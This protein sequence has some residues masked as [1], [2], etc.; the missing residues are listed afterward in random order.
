MKFSDNFIKQFNKLKF[1]AEKHSPEIL[2][3]VGIV[4]FGATLYYTVRGTV[5]ASETLSYVSEELDS[6]D[7]ESASEKRSLQLSA[8]SDVV[9]AYAPAVI[10]GS[11][12]LASFLSS[13]H[14]MRN[15]ALSM[16]AAYT[17]LETGFA[18]YR[19]R[20]IEKYG[21]DTD[22]ELKYGI[23]QKKVKSAEIDPKTGKKSKKTETVDT[24]EKCGPFGVYFKREYEVAKT[25]KTI[26]NENWQP[27]VFFN[28]TFLNAQ[29]AYFNG[30][31]DRGERVYLSEV[32]H[33]LG[34]PE[35][36]YPDARVVGWLP[37]HEDNGDADNYIRFNAYNPPYSKDYIIN[38]DGE[39]LLDFNTD[40][41]I[42]YK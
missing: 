5:T 29:L 18:E 31:L 13:N 26:V 22:R 6:L 41:V 1:S 42:L 36:D 24:I 14:I 11:V 7:E 25:G 38:D 15:R 12:T 40:G 9:K 17:T 3:G 28:V 8:A 23:V 27:N 33:I 10:C 32:L 21:D 4:A 19:K 30:A 37:K 34:I 2:V 35:D 39:V 20:V 16:A